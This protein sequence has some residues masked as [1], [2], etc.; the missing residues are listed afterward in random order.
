MNVFQKLAVARRWQVET[1][2]AEG[3]Y[4]L[5]ITEASRDLRVFVKGFRQ[6]KRWLLR[7]AAA[8]LKVS[9]IPAIPLILLLAPIVSVFL[10]PTERF[11]DESL[12]Q[13]AKD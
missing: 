3:M 4:L 5:A 12:K 6:F 2:S 8:L 9:I 7:G 1:R 10:L 11:E 13:N